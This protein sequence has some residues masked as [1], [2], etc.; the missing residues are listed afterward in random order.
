MQSEYFVLLQ[1]LYIW[2][3]RER[4]SFH[5]SPIRYEYISLPRKLVWKWLV[6]NFLIKKET[7]PEL[8]RKIFRISDSRILPLN[9]QTCYV[10]GN[11]D[12]GYFLYSVFF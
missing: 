7:T 2:Q 6:H 10:Y 4:F 11:V 1:L 9:E 5:G 12:T 8:E 3:D